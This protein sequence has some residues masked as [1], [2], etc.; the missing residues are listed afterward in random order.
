MRGHQTHI[1]KDDFF[2]AFLA[3]HKQAMTEENVQGG[4]RGARLVPFDLEKVI[5]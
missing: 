3:A 5:S 4:F 2:L 1:T